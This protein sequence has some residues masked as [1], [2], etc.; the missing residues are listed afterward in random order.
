MILKKFTK[1]YKIKSRN[2]TAE[3]IDM[4]IEIRTSKEKEIIKEILKT[5]KNIKCSIISYDNVIG[6]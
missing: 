2:L 6:L 4:T 1:Y 3:N 5:D